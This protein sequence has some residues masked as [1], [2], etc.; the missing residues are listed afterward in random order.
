MPKRPKKAIEKTLRLALL[1]APNVR[2]AVLNKPL[3]RI[4]S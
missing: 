1:I 3:Q 2:L 4:S